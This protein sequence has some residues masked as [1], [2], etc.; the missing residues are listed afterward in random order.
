VVDALRDALIRRLVGNAGTITGG[1]PW[2]LVLLPWQQLLDG[3]DSIAGGPAESDGC[4]DSAADAAWRAA[5][6]DA[7]LL[8]WWTS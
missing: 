5:N 6:T 2:S 7:P 1:L 4:G 3:L 8:V